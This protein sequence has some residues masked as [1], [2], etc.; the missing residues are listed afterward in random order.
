M[1]KGR[2]GCGA[3]MIGLLML[4]GALCQV[5][6][7]LA[8][9]QDLALASNRSASLEEVFLPAAFSPSAEQK[10]AVAPAGSS[11]ESEIIVEGLASYGHYR[12]FA[13]GSGAKL[14]TAG[15]EYDR[16]SFGRFLGARMDYTA[17]ILPL[18]LLNTATKSDIWGSPLTADREIVPGLGIYPIGFRMLW[19][20]KRAL[21]PY[22]VAKGGILGFTQKAMSQKGTYENFGL[23]YGFGMQVR[24]NER[25]DLR[26]G[27]FTDFHFSNA[28][29][30]PV[31]PGLDVMSSTLGVSYHLGQ[32]RSH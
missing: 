16:H 10:V 12:M 2:S 26:L 31:N 24:M 27:L 19:R 23:Q 4:I 1:R 25:L 29:I 21:K 14:Y 11:V 17:E 20:D 32:A 5:S 18:V 7:R 28:F 22:M 8:F 13:S 3:R 30:V 6:P 9:C 15:V